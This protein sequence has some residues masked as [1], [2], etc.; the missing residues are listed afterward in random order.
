[1]SKK[2][3]LKYFLI[4]VAYIII[5]SS[6]AVLIFSLSL[7]L[8]HREIWQ[9]NL[10]DLQIPASALVALFIGIL[11]LA[12]GMDKWLRVRSAA[13][14]AVELVFCT[15]GVY[16]VYFSANLTFVDLIEKID[17]LRIS[18][19]FYPIINIP[20]Y[21]LIKFFCV[22]LGCVMVRIAIRKSYLAELRAKGMILDNDVKQL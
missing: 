11:I 12:R 10:Q 20:Q 3:F 7:I 17:S 9:V 19:S 15:L 16:V 8:L 1:M 14:I 22:V 4:I 18:T 5:F 2:S 21:Q 13:R 6:A